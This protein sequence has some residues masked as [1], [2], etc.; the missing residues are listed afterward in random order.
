VKLI[1]CLPVV[2]SAIACGFRLPRNGFLSNCLVTTQLNS[3]SWKFQPAI[4]HVSRA[5]HTP[6]LYQNHRAL[7]LHSPQ[8]DFFTSITN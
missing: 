8:R 7:F 5:V 4:L 6:G 3:T 2:A 1:Y